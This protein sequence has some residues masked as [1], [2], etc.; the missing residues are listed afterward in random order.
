MDTS[1]GVLI[2]ENQFLQISSKTATNYMFGF[3][4][5]EHANYLLDFFWTTQGMFSNGNPVEVNNFLSFVFIL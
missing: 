2:F 5:A 4:E 1:V 3:G